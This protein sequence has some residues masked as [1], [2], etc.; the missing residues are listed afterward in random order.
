METVLW[1]AVATASISFTLSPRTKAFDWLRDYL[2]RH[3][4]KGYIYFAMAF[5]LGVETLNL[6]AR[7]KHAKNAEP[8]APAH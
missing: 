5:S 8:A 6:L 1:L 7:R 3:I 4:E 2:G